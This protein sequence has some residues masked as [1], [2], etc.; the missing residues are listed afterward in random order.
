MARSLKTNGLQE[1]A[2][3]RKRAIRQFSMGR[4]GIKDYER[5]LALI[6][7]LEAHIVSMIEKDGYGRDADE[8]WL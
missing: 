3:L 1:L 8:E 7:D 5:I 6:K 4:I 2:A